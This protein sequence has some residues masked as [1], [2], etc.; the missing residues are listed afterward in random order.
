MREHLDVDRF[1]IWKNRRRLYGQQNVI[2]E[3]TCWHGWK[4][5]AKERRKNR[6]LVVITHGNQEQSTTWT[7]TTPGNRKWIHKEGRYDQRL[8]T[9]G[10]RTDEIIA[11]WAED[12][13]T[14]SDRGLAVETGQHVSHRHPG[15]LSHDWQEGAVPFIDRP[16]VRPDRLR[17]PQGKARVKNYYNAG[18]DPNP[19]SP[20]DPGWYV[21][22][23]RFAPNEEDPRIRACVINPKLIPSGFIG[24]NQTNIIR[25]ER[26]RTR[27]TECAEGRTKSSHQTRSW[28]DRDGLERET[29]EGLAAWINTAVANQIMGMQL[30]ST[31]VNALDLERLPVPTTPQLE[32]LRTEHAAEHHEATDAS[33]ILESMQ[34]AERRAAR[35]TEAMRRVRYRIKH[36]LRAT[37]DL[38]EETTTLAL[39]AVAQLAED[40]E[41]GAAIT[42][43]STEVITHIEQHHGRRLTEETREHLEKKVWPWM[44]S[45]KLV[46]RDETNSRWIGTPKL[47]GILRK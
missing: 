39:I 27:A 14:L 7:W 28:N 45:L 12:L 34:E 37:P 8:T 44:Q 38:R 15:T 20:L 47:I 18:N 22:V 35:T 1:H 5:H 26:S 19:L 16:H 4:N 36:E 13:P 11:R 43:L 23:N 6:P 32:D 24:S 41:I 2:Q 29:A 21:A 40:E 42:D 31:Q 25:R 30:G 10:D 9:N 17:W 46:E 33:R 3:T